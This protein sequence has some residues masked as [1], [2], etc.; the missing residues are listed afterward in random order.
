MIITENFKDQVRFSN[1]LAI[2]YPELYGQLSRIL[3]AN[4][5]AHGTIMH[6]KDYW[7]RDFM[8]V[9]NGCTTY[10][11]FVYNPD[12]LQDQRKYLTDVDR[13]MDKLAGVEICAV[14]KY[15]LIVDG[16]NLVFCKSRLKDYVVMT[17]KVLTENPDKSQEQIEQIIQRAFKDCDRDFSIVWLPWDRADVCGHTDGILRYVGENEEG[18]AIVLSNLCLYDKPIAD[19][20]RLRLQQHFDIRELQLSNYCEMSWAYINCLQLRD[21]IIVPGIGNTN[22]DREAFAQIKALYPQYG[23]RIYQVEMRDFIQ[24]G[25]GAL[26]CCTWTISTEMGHLPHNLQNKARWAKLRKKAFALTDEEIQFLGDYSMTE[27]SETE[28]EIYNA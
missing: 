9:Q 6:T 4:D 1:H 15:P 8:P 27:L 23:D 20:M 25:G 10:A 3:S 11:Q 5:V 22:T 19:E 13:V 7:C 14:E 12:Y 21:V 28:W 16:G 24:K 18:R 2:D 26:N 17:E